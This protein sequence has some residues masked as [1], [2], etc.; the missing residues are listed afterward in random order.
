MKNRIRHH[1]N[2]LSI[3]KEHHFDGFDNLYDIVVDIGAFKGEFIAGL[4]EQF[5]EHN[6]IA[7]EVRARMAQYLRKRFKEYDNVVVFDGDAT[8]NL[9]N[10]LLPSQKAGAFI[11]EIY[12]NFPDPW[13]KKRHNKR[14]IITKKFLKSTEEWLDP[15]TTWIFQTDRKDLFDDTVAILDECNYAYEFFDAPPYGVTTDWENAKV[16]AG[17]KI[18]R[19]RF[20][21]AAPERNVAEDKKS[22]Y[23][24]AVAERLAGAVAFVILTVLY[25]CGTDDGH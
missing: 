22:A 15:R 1:V 13:P 7:L 19:M 11:R 20:W 21:V 5:P 6:Y 10:I 24:N 14:R 4:L 16:T 23:E 2:P 25:W 8:R 12:V 17:Q 18:Y 9:K 3:L